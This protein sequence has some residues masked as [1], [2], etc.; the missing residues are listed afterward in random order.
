VRSAI[1]DAANQRETSVEISKQT[2]DVRELITA[3]YLCN[4]GA[5]VSRPSARLVHRQKNL[6]AAA[7]EHLDSTPKT[8]RLFLSNRAL[9]T[10]ITISF[11][12]HFHF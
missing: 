3:F 5:R 8:L 12:G 1:N 4:Q 7:I 6:Y 2:L 10:D 9:D 11:V